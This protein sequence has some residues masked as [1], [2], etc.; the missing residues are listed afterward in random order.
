MSG[1]WSFDTFGGPD[2]EEGGGTGNALLFSLG[3]FDGFGHFTSGIELWLILAWLIDRLEK[4]LAILAMLSL[5]ITWLA[6]ARMLYSGHFDP[7]PGHGN[8]SLV[9]TSESTCSSWIRSLRR[10]VRTEMW[11][12]VARDWDLGMSIGNEDVEAFSGVSLA[13]VFLMIT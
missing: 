5:R 11:L 9:Q 4:L 6:E 12:G 7:R 13:W 10:G 2:T 8:A 3:G 1:L